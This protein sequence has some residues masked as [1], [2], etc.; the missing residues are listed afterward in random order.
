MGRRVACVRKL[1]YP[2]GR[3]ALRGNQIWFSRLSSP[4]RE[5]KR[6]KE[7]LVAWDDPSSVCVHGPEEVFFFSFLFFCG[8]F[9]ISMKLR[10]GQLRGNLLQG[11]VLGLQT[12]MKSLSWVRVYYIVE[13]I[14]I[15]LVTRSPSPEE[16]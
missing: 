11:K 4:R 2:L 5:R 16:V 8:L 10:V 6:G 13:Q 14:L 15:Y 7:N 12:G 9:D 3:C 1:G